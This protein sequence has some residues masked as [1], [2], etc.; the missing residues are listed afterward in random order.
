M[1]YKTQ[2]KVV[3]SNV[4]WAAAAERAVLE[5]TSASQ[6]CEHVL[7][8]Y[9]DLEAADRPAPS[10]Q[11]VHK[12]GRM[13]TVYINKFVWAQVAGLKILEGRPISAILEQLLRAYCGLAP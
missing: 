1:G 6:I 13:R 11:K 5:N 3:L 7:T 8:H 10:R 2:H 9:V 12:L 4:V